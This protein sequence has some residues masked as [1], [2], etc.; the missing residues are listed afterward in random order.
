MDFQIINCDWVRQLLT[1]LGITIVGSVHFVDL[2]NSLPKLGPFASWS[3]VGFFPYGAR[4]L[5]GL[6]KFLYP[7]WVRPHCGLSKDFP[8]VGSVHF[9][10]L[11]R[12]L[13]L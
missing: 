7:S 8:L 9:V 4:P 5:C 13:P 10:D 3:Y 1:H 6:I 2:L 11:R 12:I